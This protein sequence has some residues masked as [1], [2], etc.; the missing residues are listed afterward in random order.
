MKRARETGGD[1]G[2]SLKSAWIACISLGT[3][4]RARRL[5]QFEAAVAP[6]NNRR[7]GAA[8][9]RARVGCALYQPWSVSKSGGAGGCGGDWRGRAASAIAAA[10]RPFSFFQPIRFGSGFALVE[11]V[12]SCLRGC[13][14]IRR[15]P[16]H[17][18]DVHGDCSTRRSRLLRY[19]RHHCAECSAQR[20]GLNGGFHF[21]NRL[22]LS[23]GRVARVIIVSI[24]DLF[25][26]RKQR[27]EMPKAGH[28]KA[29]ADLGGSRL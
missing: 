6:S 7:C 20:Q 29:E 28:R 3:K 16:A 12:R 10:S 5:F 18:P 17:R 19:Q 4:L 26:R 23:G 22:P 2:V 11:R 24:F 1:K 21:L 15:R 8:A 14:R 9:C 27:L 13:C 25:V